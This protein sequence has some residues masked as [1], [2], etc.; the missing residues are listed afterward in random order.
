ML[1]SSI[2]NWYERDFGGRTGVLDFIERYLVDERDKSFVKEQ[3][4]KVK[5]EYLYYDW[6]LNK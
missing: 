4:K 3:K 1:I 6:N 2:F 5:V